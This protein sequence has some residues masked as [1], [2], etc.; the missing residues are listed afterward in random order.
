MVIRTTRRSHHQNS[1]IFRR[2]SEIS[3]KE[4][5]SGSQ[6]FVRTFITPL[7]YQTFRFNIRRLVP[8]PASCEVPSRSLL[9]EP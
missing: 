4:K 9:A 6:R 8:W 5:L 3:E 2:L 1:P 7:I